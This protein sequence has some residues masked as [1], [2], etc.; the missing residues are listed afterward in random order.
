MINRHGFAI[1]GN[2]IFG[3]INTLIAQINANI[4]LL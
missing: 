2:T 3:Q 4:G 1:A